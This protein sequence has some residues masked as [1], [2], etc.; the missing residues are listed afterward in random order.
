MRKFSVICLTVFVLIRVNATARAESVNDAVVKV[1]VTSSPGDYYRPWQS[2]GVSGQTGSGFV[3]SGNRILTNAHVVADHTY[4]QVKK[5]SGA[6]KYTARVLVVGH[7]CDL[8]LLNVDDPDFFKD[9]MPIEFGELPKMQDNVTVI[10]YPQGGDKL[11]ITKGVVSRLEMTAY[12]QSA[13]NLLAVQI[14]AAINPGNSGG[15]V[16]KDGKLV[17]VAMQILE[18]GQNIGYMIP[19]P[20][21]RHF[22]DDFNDGQYD[23]FPVLGIEYMTTENPTVGSYYGAGD[24]QGGV[25]ITQV[26]PFS[27]ADAFLQED[28][29]IVEVGGIPIAEDGTFIF[30]EDERLQLPYLITEKQ[31]HD[32]I[33]FKV[34]RNKKEMEIMLQLKPF[35]PL[36]PYPEHFVR[37]PYYIYGGLVFSV[38]STDLLQSWGKNWWQQAPFSFSYFVLGPG[39]LNQDKR[40]E[41]V[42]LLNLLSDDLNVGYAGETNTVITAVDGKNFASFREFVELIQKHQGQYIVFET[43]DGAKLVLDTQGIE[44]VNQEIMQRNHIPAPYS[45]DVEKWLSSGSSAK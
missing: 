4:V 37:P 45:K 18:S 44:A 14:D 13:R 35:T 29:L 28:D 21:I 23:G 2:Q 11:S 5:N 6:R 26:L 34:I 25:V 15:P 30:R 32:L 41:V 42:I 9:V 7:D 16:L 10:G 8:A 38:L 36:V 40:K 17:G 19:I 12:S 22:F 31:I 43:I 24:E 20:I 3:I 1:F 33:A 39:R 27:P